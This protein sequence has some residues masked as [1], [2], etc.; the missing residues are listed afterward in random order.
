[1]LVNELTAQQILALAR[2]G[3]SAEQIS[4]ALEVP[5]EQ[6]KL[7][8]VSNNLGSAADRDI[9]DEQLARLRQRAYDLAMY[10]QEDAVSARMTMFLIERDKPSKKIEQGNVLVNINNAIMGAQQNF[11]RMLEEYKD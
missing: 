2:D 5:L 3:C 10:S 9:N 11:N 4:G 8:L 7:A 6:V 1:M